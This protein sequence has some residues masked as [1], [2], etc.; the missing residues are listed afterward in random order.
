MRS[1]SDV[2]SEIEPHRLA[3]RQR[4]CDLLNLR[5]VAA[6][7]EAIVAELA[8]QGL[9]ATVADVEAIKAEMFLSEE[10]DAAGVPA[11]HSWNNQDQL[12]DKAL[13][14]AQR[15]FDSTGSVE[16]AKH[17]LDEV[18]EQTSRDAD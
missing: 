4:I 16:R 3:L 7:P 13:L 12:S 17:A 5:G 1:K 11:S 15:L 2:S 18:A 6:P 8:K 14:E 9:V 10:R